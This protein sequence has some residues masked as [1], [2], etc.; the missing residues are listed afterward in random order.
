VESVL[1]KPQTVKDCLKSDEI[2]FERCPVM[3]IEFL[4]RLEKLVFTGFRNNAYISF[5]FLPYGWW[6]DGAI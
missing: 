5:C 2:S 3:K 4:D 6:R 1:A